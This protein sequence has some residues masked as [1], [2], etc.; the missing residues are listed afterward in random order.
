MSAAAKR[1]STPTRVERATL[2]L[3]FGL[4]AA[5]AGGWWLPDWAQ[6]LVILALGKGL[7]VL[8]LMLLMR[9]GLV[10]FGQG[11]YYCIGAYAA[12]AVTL[13]IGLPETLVTS[14]P[15]LMPL[16]GGVVA[17]AIPF[18]LGFQLASYR[19]HIFAMLSLAL[20]MILN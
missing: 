6:S 7:V 5:L 16:F 13:N 3:G 15:V 4:A 2:W 14:D 10:S 9:N 1:V 20:S 12:V 18:V 11:L 17:R 19:G 8:G